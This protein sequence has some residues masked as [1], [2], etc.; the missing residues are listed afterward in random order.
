MFQFYYSYYLLRANFMFS[1]FIHFF[2]FVLWFFLIEVQLLYNIVL[3]SAIHQH[4]S[5]TGIHYDPSLLNP[6]PISHPIP[7]FRLSQSTRLS[8]LCYTVNSHWLFIL[9]MEM[10]T[11]H[12]RAKEKPRQGGRRGAIA[13]KIKPDTHQRLPYFGFRYQ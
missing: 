7:N 2:C 13:F 4:E 6:P 5:A 10:Y 12:P 3:I 9:Y 1:F 8:S 11:P